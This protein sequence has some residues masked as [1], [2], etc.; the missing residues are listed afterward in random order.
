MR[1]TGHT[2]LVGEKT[3][4]STGN[5][6]KVSIIPG[7]CEANICSKHDFAADGS[8]FVGHGFTPD[9]PVTET[10]NS[11]FKAKRD[12]ALTKALQ[13]LNKGHF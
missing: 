2:T 3:G 9:I 10:Y 11:Y 1:A 7:V 8:D 6:I 5:G 13:W 4:G 12:N